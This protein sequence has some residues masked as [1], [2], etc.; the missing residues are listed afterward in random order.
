MEL[1]QMLNAVNNGLEALVE[2]RKQIMIKL[3]NYKLQ[4]LLS[5]S[6]NIVDYTHDNY[7]N[8]QVNIYIPSLLFEIIVTTYSN[9]T[10]YDINYND[11]EHVE[12]N[13]DQTDTSTFK[14]VT[15]VFPD[16]KEIFIDR[17]EEWFI[18]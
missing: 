5:I 8:R 18:I 9:N 12:F 13:K 10:V 11:V 1:E 7:G 15:D 14:L 4:K 3:C 2:Q 16:F 17:L 6:F